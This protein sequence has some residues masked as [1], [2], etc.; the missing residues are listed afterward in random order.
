MIDGTRQGSF[1]S[2]KTKTVF[3]KNSS[4][5]YSMI[6]EHVCLYYVFI[7]SVRIHK[8]RFNGFLLVKHVHKK[9][10]VL[11]CHRFF[12]DPLKHFRRVN[13]VLHLS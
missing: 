1:L 13:V 9:P 5:N 3:V 2:D 8:A 10:C 11:V 7:F 12:Y 4:V 6:S